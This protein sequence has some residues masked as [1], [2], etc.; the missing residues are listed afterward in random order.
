MQNKL[1]KL[2]ATKL[3]CRR[4]AIWNPNKGP[5]FLRKNYLATEDT[6]QEIFDV[7]NKNIWNSELERTNIEIGR[8]RGS[9]GWCLGLNTPAGEF[10]TKK[11]KLTPKWGCLQWFITILAHEMV[12]HWQCSIY[13]NERYES[14]MPWSKSFIMS[15]GPSF[16]RWKASLAKYDIP[17][18]LQH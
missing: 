15:H 16:H 5:E 14:G 17:L 6:A 7:L 8:I 2:M 4:N 11:I 3:P 1:T 9:Y 10:Y 12:H 13:S 18:K